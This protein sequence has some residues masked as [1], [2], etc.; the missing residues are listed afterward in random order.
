MILNDK[1]YE[2]VLMRVTSVRDRAILLSHDILLRNKANSVKPS[3]D[4]E[5]RAAIVAFLR[6][7]GPNTT[8]RGA[9]AHKLADMIEAGAHRKDERSAA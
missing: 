7:S 1:Q 8:V 3:G 5:E 9:H 6:A 4:A 2:E